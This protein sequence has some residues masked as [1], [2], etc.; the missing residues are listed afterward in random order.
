MS[1]PNSIVEK[2]AK[3]LN[4][5][6]NTTG[7]E[8]E[9]FMARAQEMASTNSIDLAKA[10]HIITAKERTVPIMRSIKMGERGTQG[11]STYVNLFV[12]IA[13]ANDVK[14]DIAHNSTYVYA[15]GFEE[16]VDVCEAFFSSLLTQMIAASEV[17]RKTEG[18]KSEKVWRE[19]YWRYLDR[20]GKDVPLK[21]LATQ[22]VWVEEGYKPMTWR[23]ARLDFQL[24]FAST[25]GSRLRMAQAAAEKVAS[26]VEKAEEQESTGTELVL[27][28][29]R[30]SVRDFYK[31]K[32]TARGSYEGY[33]GNNSGASRAG[34]TAGQKARL[35]GNTSLPGSRK[36]LN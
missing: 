3:L 29:K 36:E 1:T 7:H 10:R 2:I 4:Q 19:G 33:S 18:W 17:Y 14:C 16:D 21:R 15:Y 11:L 25:V 34:G 26:M 12:G 35:S 5:A 8:S 6:E 24:A 13:G 9:A 31:S 30:E 23:T 28:E 20:N 27:V 32:S 22:D